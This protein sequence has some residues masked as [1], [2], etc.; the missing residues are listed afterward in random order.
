MSVERRERL[1]GFVIYAG[2]S[3][4]HEPFRDFGPLNDEI[5]RRGSLSFAKVR[6][7][8]FRCLCDRRELARIEPPREELAPEELSLL[9]G[10][11]EVL[12]ALK[13][14]LDRDWKE[15]ASRLPVDLER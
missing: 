13:E 14:D 6:E 4:K 11:G 8:R 10:P 3:F 7:E 5:R 15:S 9:C 1:D 2:R 12:R